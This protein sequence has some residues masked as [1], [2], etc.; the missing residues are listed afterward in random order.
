MTLADLEKE[1][2]RPELF[3]ITRGRIKMPACRACAYLAVFDLGIYSARPVQGEAS[4]CIAGL[5]ADCQGAEPL[6]R[7]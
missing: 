1:T 3:A 2:K 5:A 6:P 4:Q 7:L